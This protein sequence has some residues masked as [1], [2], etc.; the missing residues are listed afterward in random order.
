MQRSKLKQ[1]ASL[2]YRHSPVSCWILGVTSGALIAAIIALDLLLPF[3]SFITI[4]LLVIPIIFSATIQHAF[5]KT[6]ATITMG[7]S[8]RTF[9]LYY[10]REFFGSY[11][12][13]F[14]F[15]KSAIVFFILEMAVSSVASY[16]FLLTNSQFHASLDSLNNLLATYE[17]SYADIMN[18]LTANNYLLF[19]YL[20]ISIVPAFFLAVLFFI[21]NTSRY[22]VIVY[23]KMHLKR[24]DSRFAKLVY[25]FAL[26]GRRMEMF[27]A[28]MSLN[29]PLYLLLLLGF[30]GGA[31][32][33]YYFYQDLMKIFAFGMVGGATLGT[34][35]LP[36]YFSNMQAFYDMYAPLYKDV[37]KAVTSSLIGNL[38]SDIEFSEQEKERLEETLADRDGPLNDEDDG[39]DNKKDPEGS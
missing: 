13:I 37:T 19:N 36:F 27:G 2:Y 29:W 35:F 4:P 8:I 12:I 22:S 24:T 23:Y 30:G 25:Q 38:Q 32:L 21:Y 17:F 26:R 10:K 34:F 11:S 28:Y 33:G 20:I 5:L 39:E 31:F 7:S 1:Q 6:N 9:A 3:F 18:A 15:I 14:N 16:I